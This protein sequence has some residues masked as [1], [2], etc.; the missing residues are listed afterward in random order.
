MKNYIKTISSF[1]I[2]CFLPTFCVL[3]LQQLLNFKFDNS[4]M[5]HLMY[6]NVIAD[7]VFFFIFLLL[8]RD[9]IKKNAPIKGDTTGKK[10][11]N[12]ITT[13]II[14]TILFF[15][16]KIVSSILVTIILDMLG[17]KQVP[18]NQEM[19][20]ILFKSAPFLMT[21]T[22]AFMV[23]VTEELL[24][25]GSIRRVIKNKWVFVTVSGLLFGLVHVLKFDLPIFVLLIL[26]IFVD[27]IITSSM[28]KNKKVGL[29]ICT[30]LV[31]IVIMAL[32]LHLLSGDLIRLLTNIDLSEAINSLVYISAGVFLAALYVKYDNIY[33]TIG[34]HILNNLISY[35]I[36]FTLL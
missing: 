16:I 33:V 29:T 19:I 25:R 28:S 7:V 13:V 32:S 12:Y 15:V 35:I 23:P 24:F 21:L 36:L 6:L 30:T 5:N 8:S 27:S 26:G 20:E 14:C 4:N 17:L 11:I 10:I 18:N 22:G 1:L 34:I 31:M 9:I 2:Y 3:G